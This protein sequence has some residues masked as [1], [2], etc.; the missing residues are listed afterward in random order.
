MPRIFKVFIIL[1]FLVNLTSCKKPETTA[2]KDHL[3]MP[4]ASSI[5]S[6][7]PAIS[8]DT[9]SG[10][11]VYQVYEQL[12]QYSYLKRPYEIEPL[13]ADGMPKVSDDQLTVT[14]K[15]KKGVLYHPDLSLKKGR[16]VIAEDFITQIKRL[17]YISTR[18]TGSWLF[19][20]I[21]E[22]FNK[23]KKD[24]GS[25]F[26]LFKHKSISGLKAID[27]QTLQ[28]KL[29][30]PYP[31]LKYALAMSFT[32]P[33]PMES[34][35]YYKNMLE[36]SMIGTGPFFLSQWVKSSKIVLEKFDGYRNEFFPNAGDKYSHEQSLLNDQGRKIPF[37]KKV[38]MNVIKEDQT[39]WLNFMAKKIDFL[40][41][42]KDN[43]AMA[44]DVDGSLAKNL[45]DKGIGMQIA[46]TQTYW[47]LAFNMR[48]PLLGK[49]K[50]LRLAIAHA[51]NRDR[52]ISFFTNNRALKSS[53]I[54]P[55]SVFGYN[56][57]KNVP[58]EYNIEK[59]KYYLKKA[60]Y[61][62]G[63]G[64]PKIKFDTRGV[65]ATWRQRAEFIQSELK[66]INIQVTIQTNTFPAYLEK[67]RKGDLE[68]YMDGWA[69]DYPD[70]ENSLQLLYSKNA[71]PGPNAAFYN[72][73]AFDTLFDQIKILPD[74][75]Q[76]K[77]LLDKAHDLIQEDFPWA[78]LYCD[79]SYMLYSKRLR[80]FRY[81]S[82]INNFIKYIRK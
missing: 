37:L 4:I 36:E 28:I 33:I 31:Q 23:F 64:L 35:I 10:R 44:I 71:P 7:D 60:G 50:N 54:Y 57:S 17:A 47:W 82:S 56:A 75:Q 62:E 25:N 76:K 72:S 3:K 13:L 30:R 2:D 20:G 18:S 41:I 70:A 39:R 61:P 5:D 43:F 6:V 1:S 19:E 24:V 12:Y 77:L 69:M 65:N 16:S 68:F 53:T 49:N 14:I 15:I 52:M 26:D 55:P 40:S 38:T 9:V 73:K 34:V 74:G 22:G 32:S 29:K 63:K 46:P 66:K 59:A 21:I 67:A 8:Y 51:I 80:N 27:D 11:V 48:N 42:P 78:M 79:R 81:S 58:F 45:S